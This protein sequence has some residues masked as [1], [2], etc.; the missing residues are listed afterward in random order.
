MVVD[1]VNNAISSPKMT[2]PWLLFS[3]GIVAPLT[4]MIEHFYFAE[5]CWPVLAFKY[6]T[7]HVREKMS[8]QKDLGHTFS[9]MLRWLKVVA[10]FVCLPRERTLVHPD[11]R[12][13]QRAVPR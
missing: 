11:C 1:S 2:G 7:V 4:P 10:A 13:L 5:L 3:R 9:C 12:S 8:E 6:A